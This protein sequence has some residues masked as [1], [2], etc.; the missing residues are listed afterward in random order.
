MYQT[1][2]GS[3]S[4][5]TVTAHPE[6]RFHVSTEPPHLTSG[7]GLLEVTLHDGARRWTAPHRYP[8]QVGPVSS[9]E[10]PLPG[11]PLLLIDSRPVLQGTGKA[12]VQLPPGEYRCSVQAGGFA[13]WWPLTIEAGEAIDLQARPSPTGELQLAPGRFAGKIRYL[14]P[15]ASFGGLALGLMFLLL[16]SFV[17]LIKWGLPEVRLGTLATAILYGA[18]A[19]AAITL[20][21]FMTGKHVHTMQRSAQHHEQLRRR[22]DEPLYGGVLDVYELP[23]TAS[24]VPEP[25]PY[26]SGIVLDLAWE[27]VWQ[28]I[29]TEVE[30]DWEA[31]QRDG[32]PGPVDR[33]PWIGDPTV[34]IDDVEIAVTWGRWWIPLPTGEHLVD[35]AIPHQDERAQSEDDDDHYTT[36]TDTV[37]TE[38]DHLTHLQLDGLVVQYYLDEDE[39]VLQLSEFDADT[40]TIRV[41]GE[42]GPFRAPRRETVPVDG[43]TDPSYCHSI[44]DMT[45]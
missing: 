3:A 26:R 40:D 44:L 7:Y 32:E 27:T 41:D 19:A 11:I 29:D 21:L 8:G 22:S 2:T 43:Q 4:P 18:S 15:L 23:P 45:E 13:G 39:P 14:R 38:P 17:L 42:V 36:W 6:S 34:L 10:Y 37:A 9:P 16:C 20:W 35:V 28:R 30:I 25:G 12:W 1:T 33:R 24:V 5:S 31:M